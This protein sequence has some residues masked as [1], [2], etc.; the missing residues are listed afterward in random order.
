MLDTGFEGVA[1]AGGV[2][3]G[4]ERFPGPG[5]RRRVLLGPRTTLSPTFP[6]S[7]RTGGTVDSVSVPKPDTEV[8]GTVREG[9]R[10]RSLERIYPEG[11]HVRRG[12]QREVLGR[13]GHT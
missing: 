12:P 3:P 10:S 1:R 7:G 4:P 2:G 8:G 9:I 11:G 13:R 5:R 6:P